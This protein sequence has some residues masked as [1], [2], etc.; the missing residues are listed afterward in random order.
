MEKAERARKCGMH[1]AEQN[2]PMCGIVSL[3]QKIDRSTF[4]GQENS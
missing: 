4:I 2:A 1:P 3:I